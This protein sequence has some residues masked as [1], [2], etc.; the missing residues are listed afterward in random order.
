MYDLGNGFL[1]NK[2]L[3]ATHTAYELVRV[4]RSFV[5]FRIDTTFGCNSCAGSTGARLPCATAIL[6]IALNVSRDEISIT[7]SLIKK[8]NIKKYY[9]KTDTD[10]IG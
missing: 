10:L 9:T 1:D 4:G 8:K 2:Y 5:D 7:D 6:Q 3:V